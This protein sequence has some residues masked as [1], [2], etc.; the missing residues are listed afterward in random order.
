MFNSFAVHPRLNPIGGRDPREAKGVT[1]SR[2]A[3][4]SQQNATFDQ[5][6]HD[7]FGAGLIRIFLFG[8]N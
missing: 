1:S 7:P 8:P 6:N 4:Q 2:R 5:G 3:G